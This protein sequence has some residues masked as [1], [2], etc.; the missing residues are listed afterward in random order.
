MLAGWQPAYLLPKMFD[1]NGH[2]CYKLEPFPLFL[3]E[4]DARRSCT[5]SAFLTDQARI[6]AWIGPEIFHKPSEVVICIAWLRF[7]SHMFVER[8]RIR[9]FR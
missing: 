2:V 1:I 5:A 3:R 8:E 4:Q 9:C 6:I 7:V